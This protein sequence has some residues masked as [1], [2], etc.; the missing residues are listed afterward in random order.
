MAL[1]SSY[2]SCCVTHGP[3]ITCSSRHSLPTAESFI[4]DI[5]SRMPTLC[6][7]PIRYSNKPLQ[8][9]LGLCTVNELRTR[10]NTASMAVPL[11]VA[12]CDVKLGHPVMPP[13]LLQADQRPE[14]EAL[15]SGSHA[16]TQI[17]SVYG[18]KNKTSTYTGTQPTT[19]LSV[20]QAS[21]DV[22]RIVPSFQKAK[23]TATGHG[24]TAV[25]KKR[26]SSALSGKESKR[27]K[28][29]PEPTISNDKSTNNSQS[30]VG[31]VCNYRQV[32]LMMN[33]L[34]HNMWIL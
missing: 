12:S 19:S 34:L 9:T 24:A 23:A 33:Y 20:S 27:K 28:V 2:P 5:H 17:A 22:S 25:V 26:T 8:P 18:T 4:N 6:G 15:K 3:P 31:G 10:P 32:R 16:G 14:H 7:E 30:V 21:S 1:F 29:T 13:L 11:R